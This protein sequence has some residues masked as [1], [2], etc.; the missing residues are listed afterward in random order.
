MRHL[1]LVS[2]LFLA[3]AST[4]P[5]QDL[6]D[7]LRMYLR[8]PTQFSD[9]TVLPDA[10]PQTEALLFV[11][12]DSTN[13]QAGRVFLS[14]VWKHTG[15]LDSGLVD[16]EE[17]VSFQP[18]AVCARAGVSNVIYVAGWSP[19]G[20]RVIIEEWTFGLGGFTVIQPP[21]GGPVNVDFVPPAIQKSVV[22]I[23]D[24]AELSPIVGMGYQPHSG[25]LVL[26]QDGSAGSL[27]QIEVDGANGVCGASVCPTACQAGSVSSQVIALRSA[28]LLTGEFLLIGDSVPTWSLV[29]D[30][31]DLQKEV[32][33]LLDAD[34]DGSF[35]QC[36]TM[37]YSAFKVAYPS[38]AFDYEYVDS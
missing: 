9:T 29:S 19:R 24:P 31:S 5:A 32:S 18:T 2:L 34:Q 11:G 20:P 21:G 33:V 4:T 22:W 8:Y 1:A 10:D 16:E 27:V 25:T 26:C 3:G 13:P 23:S 30:A 36:Q 7:E 14:W 15:H 37:T 12:L 6:P 17:A 28:R 35:E 38:Q